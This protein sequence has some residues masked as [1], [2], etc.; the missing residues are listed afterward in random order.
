MKLWV[1]MTKGWKRM[2][3]KKAKGRAKKA[4]TAE[5]WKAKAKRK[6]AKKS[7][8][9]RSTQTNAGQVKAITRRHLHRRL[10]LPRRHRHPRR[11]PLRYPS[12]NQNLTRHTVNNSKPCSALNASYHAPLLMP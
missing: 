1:R 4:K 6:K 2:M 9:K 5:T 3:A 12:R 10:L 8:L 11:C 7:K